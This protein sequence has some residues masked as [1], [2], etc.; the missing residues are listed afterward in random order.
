MRLKELFTQA[1]RERDGAV[2]SRD[3]ALV[4]RDQLREENQRLRDFLQQPTNSTSGTDS[5]YDSMS[6]T[7]DSGSS[8][9]DVSGLNLTANAPLQ[10]VADSRRPSL[11]EMA[12]TRGF[13]SDGPPMS[14]SPLIK[15]ETT[16]R[17]EDSGRVLAKLTTELPAIQLDYDEL[18][19]DFVLT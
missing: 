1:S 17:R 4:E 18:G 6:W 8:F 9:S 5:G 7:C 15:F 16:M 12:E 14:D 19:L 10:E 13:A 2:Q 3:A 11:W